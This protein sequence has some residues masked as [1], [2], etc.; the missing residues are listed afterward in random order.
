[1]EIDIENDIIN[2]ISAGIHK[3]YPDTPIYV[4]DVEQGLKE[5]CFF[6]MSL[7]SSEDRLLNNRAKRNMSFDVH[8]FTKGKNSERREVAAV[9]Y[10]ALRQIT[11]LDGS[12]LNGMYMRHEIHD[13]VLHFFVEYR[14]IIY[15]SVEE[16][17]SMGNI[18]SKVDII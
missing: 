13:D 14:P 10:K 16:A 8:Y 2:G 15:Y 7:E 9:L 3:L 12:M 1:M 4:D 6:I 17:D 5:P 18:K 11:L